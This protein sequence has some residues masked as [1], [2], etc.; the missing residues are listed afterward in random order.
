M[1]IRLAG[2]CSI[3]FS[4]QH[5]LV[6]DLI[7]TA[8]P[9][10]IPKIQRRKLGDAVVQRLSSRLLELLALLD[11]HVLILMSPMVLAG[12]GGNMK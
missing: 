2:R 10:E 4:R 12:Q 5:G 7:L 1:L 8:H 3:K 9:Q 6:I 11:G